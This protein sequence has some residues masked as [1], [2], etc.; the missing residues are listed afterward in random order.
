MTFYLAPDFP[1]ETVKPTTI[2]FYAS[3]GKEAAALAYAERKKLRAGYSRDATSFDG[4]TE[5]CTRVVIMPSV[6]GFHRAKIMEAYGDKVNELAP[7]DAYGKYLQTVG[8]KAPAN[9]DEV[10][11]SIGKG[12]RGKFY[13]KQGDERIAGPFDTEAEAQ[14]A[15]AS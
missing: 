9:P 1:E 2:F 15:L 3:E 5:P 14:A 8:G 6:K 10:I 4:G 12:P 7:V 13:V 11:R